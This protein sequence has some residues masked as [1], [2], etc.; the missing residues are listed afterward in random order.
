MA[1]T[2][3]EIDVSATEALKQFSK[4]SPGTGSLQNKR[5]NAVFPRVTKGGLAS[6]VIRRSVLLI[7][8]RPS[9]T[10][11]SLQLARANSRC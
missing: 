11:V 1:A 3:A 9:V 10:T 2:K 7:D 4:M 6:P 5:S 8:V